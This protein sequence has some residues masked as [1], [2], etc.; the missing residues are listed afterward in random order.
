M[1]CPK[2]GFENNDSAKTCAKCGAFI[3]PNDEAK[4]RHR[5]VVQLPSNQSADETTPIDTQAVV[6][7]AHQRGSASASDSKTPTPRRRTGATGKIPAIKHPT[8]ED[9]KIPAEERKA[10]RPAEQTQRMARAPRTKQTIIDD[11]V[12]AAVSA[13]EMH[14]YTPPHGRN[15]AASNRRSVNAD[16]R[17]N[18]QQ[19][20]TKSLIILIAALIIIC[21]FALGLFFVNTGVNDKT[22]RFDTDGGTL[23]GNQYVLVDDELSKPANPTR[24]GY[25]FDGWYLD[26]NYGEEAEFPIKVTQD[27][28]LYAKWKQA[29]M[30]STPFVP[31]ATTTTPEQPQDEATTN[32]ASSPSISGN[33]GSRPSGGSNSGNSGASKP[34]TKP[35]QGGNSSGGGSSSSSSINSNPASNGPVNI[36]LVASNGAQ[37]SGTVTLHDGY[38]IPNSS[39]KAYTIDELRA[40]GLNDAE[41]C[42]ARNEP[43][44][45]M[46]YSFRNPGLQ[47]YF[48]ARSWYHN[49]GW[50]GQLPENSAG[51][52]TAHNLLALAQ[53]SASASKWLSLRTY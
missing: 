32:D 38:V 1:R 18:Q 46:G 39:T 10:A 12:L 48:N 13:S 8:H 29:T 19:K 27:M 41:L 49:K 14:S 44:A 52:I 53:Q 24:P 33:S 36:T 45:R 25:V 26:A 40:L 43:Y 34:S 16:N 3:D 7:A 30:S 37:L 42:I 22:V 17:T 31:G 9:G 15:Y 11:A 47:A 51:Y 2:C 5:K 28:T 50:R 35:S 6:A 20:R 21:L 4:K 23:I